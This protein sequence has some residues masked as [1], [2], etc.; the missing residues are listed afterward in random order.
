MSIAG[1]VKPDGTSTALPEGVYDMAQLG[2]NNLDPELEKKISALVNLEPDKET[3]ASFKLEIFFRSGAR[4]NVPVRGILCAWTN[5]G[6][7]NGGGDQI[8]YFCPQQQLTDPTRTCLEPI[9]VQF[10]AGGNVVC[11]KCERVSKTKVLVGQIIAEQEMYRWAA[12][13]TRF[14]HILKCSADLRVSIERGS[15]REASVKELERERGGE[16]YAKVEE[17]REWITYPL[18]SLIRDTASGATLE[19]RIRAFLEA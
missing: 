3:K 14:F 19:S 10:Q 2:L 7:L 1:Y 9:D 11:T 18:A 17:A 4:H 8:V 15:I 13:A 5:G 16:A 12:M 6:F